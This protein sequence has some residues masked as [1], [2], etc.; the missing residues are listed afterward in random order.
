[1]S[2][3][4]SWNHVNLKNDM[5]K[6]VPPGRW[7]VLSHRGTTWCWGCAD[8]HRQQT[9]RRATCACRHPLWIQPHPC[10]SACSWSWPPCPWHSLS[11]ER[12]PTDPPGDSCAPAAERN[13]HLLH[14]LICL[15]TLVL[16]TNTYKCN[17]NV[18]NQQGT[19]HGDIYNHLMY[20][21]SFTF[22][23]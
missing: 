7:R 15:F 17:L 2:L 19:C 3:F 23:S 20:L 4:Q 6:Y 14:C 13:K 21:F 10:R 1:M 12:G 8:D 22:Y 5:L 11:P 18:S 16:R 9:D